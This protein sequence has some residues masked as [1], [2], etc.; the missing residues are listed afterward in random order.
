[1]VPTLYDYSAQS[2]PGPYGYA[3]EFIGKRG[4]HEYFSI[5]V[6][7][8][9][10]QSQ[11]GIKTIWG[12]MPQ[13]MTSFTKMRLG[14]IRPEQIVAVRAGETVEVLLDPLWNGVAETLAV[15][16]PVNEHLY[17]LIENRQR[18]GVDR[19][20]PSQGVLILQV[21]DHI[22]ES[23]GPVRVMNAHPGRPHFKKAP[24]KVGEKYENHEHGLVVEVVGREGDQYR[25]EIMKRGGL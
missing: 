1:V 9:D 25:L 6:G 23:T 16:I 15:R 10:I 12:Y 24:F 11:H 19:H 4:G 2:S 7:P 8:W 22:P 3:N 14:W 20:L 13:G 17:Y 18:V 5:Y 21:D